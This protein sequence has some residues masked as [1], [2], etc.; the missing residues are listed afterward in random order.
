MVFD[1]MLELTPNGFTNIRYDKFG[2]GQDINY[3]QGLFAPL[4]AERIPFNAHVTQYT[5][6]KLATGK[7][8]NIINAEWNKKITDWLSIY[9]TTSVTKTASGD[10]KLNT[11][12]EITTY[13]Q[14]NA[15]RKILFI[16][17]VFKEQEDVA[18]SEADFVVWNTGVSIY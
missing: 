13:T 1:K 6:K 9:G 12:T 7:A 2:N 17:K 16:V 15:Q 3:P 14:K 18:G 4:A 11:D 10:P 5:G 8:T